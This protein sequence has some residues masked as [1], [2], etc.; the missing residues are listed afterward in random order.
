MTTAELID[1]AL[2]MQDHVSR[3]EEEDY[4]KNSENPDKKEDE[5]QDFGPDEE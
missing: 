3:L 4:R 5:T 1:Y 2:T